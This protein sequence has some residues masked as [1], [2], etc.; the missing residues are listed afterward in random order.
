MHHPRPLVAGQTLREL[1]QLGFG[2]DRT[3]LDLHDG[4]DQFPEPLI[5]AVV[6]VESNFNPKAI[7]HA[8]AQGLMQ[9]M[10]ATAA[11]MGVEDTFDP[12]QNILGGTRYLRLLGFDCLYQNDFDD[13]TVATLS[14]EQ[15]RSV[16][17][18]DR[19]L[20]VR[21]EEVIVRPACEW[22]LEE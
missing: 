1:Q 3:G 7:S 2:Q 9:L 22:L 6:A 21:V 20:Q 13:E 10:P 5:R 12:R 15:H 14:R 19:A 18:R 16:L 4:G 8:G 11:D 17:T